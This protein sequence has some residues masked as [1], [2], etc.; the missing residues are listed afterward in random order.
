M[1]EKRKEEEKRMGALGGG[2]DIFFI[3]A[4]HY[5]PTVR[6]NTRDL[7][8]VASLKKGPE[9]QIALWCHNIILLCI[10][11]QQFGVAE[12]SLLIRYIGSLC[13]ND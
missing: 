5:W 8:P 7:R 3:K 4:P 10:V 12:T 1:D 2:L 11:W 9:I 13:S 6:K